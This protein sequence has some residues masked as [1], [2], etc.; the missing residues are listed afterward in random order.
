MLPK[1]KALGY[2]Q[3]ELLTDTVIATA[4]ETA[5]GHEFHYS[6]IAEMP[7]LIERTYII[8]RQ[9]KQ[10]D[11]EGY[12]HRNCL[13]SYVHLHFGSNS[14]IAETFYAACLNYK[15]VNNI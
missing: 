6:E 10:L 14:L 1:R 13:A 4:G 2:R 8:T 5:R 12:R 3:V 15:T 11:L 9:G 7:D